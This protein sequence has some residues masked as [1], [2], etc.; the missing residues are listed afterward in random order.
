[1][2]QRRAI[3]LMAVSSGKQA[4]ANK[5]SLPEQ[6]EKLHELVAANNWDVVDMIIVPGHSRVYYT[7]REF[8]EDALSEG[9]PAPMRMFEHWEKGDFD[10]FACSS[11]DR[12]GRE[13]SIFAEVVGRTIDCG[14]IVYTLRDGEINSGNRRM[15]VSMGG[16]QAA[17]EIDELVR[18]H[19]F[20]MQKNARLGLPTA[21]V[22][23]ILSHTTVGT[24]A[25]R[26]TVV[27]EDARRLFADIAEFLLAGISWRQMPDLLA[28]RG[29]TRKDGRRLGAST[30]RKWLMHPTCWGNSAQHFNDSDFYSTSRNFWVFDPTEPRPDYVA[31]HYGTHPP[32]YEGVL[33]DRVKAELRRRFRATT[34]AP[35]PRRKFSG[36]VVCDECHYACNY[37]QDGAWLG[38][39]CVSRRQVDIATDCPNRRYVHERKIVAF[40]TDLLNTLA[41]S[42]HWDILYGDE[43]QADYAAR[44]AEVERDLDAVTE[45][46]GQLMMEKTTVHALFKRK[47][48]ENMKALEEKAEA[49]TVEKARLAK[50]AVDSAPN[51]VQQE[52]LEDYRKLAPG[53]LWDMPDH[54]INQFL[55]AILRNR[56]F[57]INE[58][59]VIGTTGQPYKYAKPKKR[60]PAT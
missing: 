6:D 39:H 33:G 7:Y 37:K 45:Q 26:Q 32:M 25:D 2:K 44:L 12:F 28:E 15:F 41:A 35:Q 9:I 10:V 18:R 13:Q 4:A 59:E 16:Y 8:A 30:L 55:A 21:P 20:G 52:R 5:Q 27:N 23:H 22:G 17:V 56:R 40:A 11:G 36:L 51:A 58:G 48:E 43:H 34:G 47:L 49:L 24:G 1:M 50:M 29:H 14:A 3:L 42:D 53:A 46:A 38:V 60:T 19:R 54:E 57:V 31:I